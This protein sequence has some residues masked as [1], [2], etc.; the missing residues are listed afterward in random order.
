[1]RSLDAAKIY[2][3]NSFDFVFID[4]DHSYKGAVLDIRHWYPKVKVGGWI[5]GHDYGHPRIGEVKKAV[6]EVFTED[7]IELSADMTWFVKKE[8]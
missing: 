8:E 1:M 2:I 7:K 6:D 5:G 4:A 3:N